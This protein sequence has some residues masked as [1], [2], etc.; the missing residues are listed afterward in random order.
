MK[1]V[2]CALKLWIYTWTLNISKNNDAWKSTIKKEAV[3]HSTTKQLLDLHVNMQKLLQSQLKEKENLETKSLEN[4]STV[5]LPKID[6]ISF[7]GEKTKWVEFWD[8]FQC[9]VHND[10]SLK[11]KV[12]WPSQ[13]CYIRFS[14]LQ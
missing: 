14:T 11:N 5:K 8:S 12:I 2:Y 4:A 10:K 7:G 1:T 3:D 6:M 13:M 9:A